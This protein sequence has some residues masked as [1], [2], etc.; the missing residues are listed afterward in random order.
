MSGHVKYKS[1]DIRNNKA[2]VADSAIRPVVVA[3]HWKYYVRSTFLSLLVN[4]ASLQIFFNT[5]Q[6]CPPSNVSSCDVFA[7][8]VAT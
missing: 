7:I 8:S 6:M 1:E 3:L 5:V 4:Q 2:S